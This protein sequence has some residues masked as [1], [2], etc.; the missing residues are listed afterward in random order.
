MGKVNYRINQ[1]ELIKLREWKKRIDEARKGKYEHPFQY[2]KPFVKVDDVNSISRR[3][4][5]YCPIQK[6]LVHLL[7]DGEANAYKF[8]IYQPDV[9]G[10]RE[11][12]PLHL[13]KTLEIAE[14]LQVI[15]PRNWKTKELYIMT[16]DLL[17]DRVDLETGEVYQQAANF[18]YWD[19][20]YEYVNDQLVV[21]KSWRTWQKALI[22]K[23]YWDEKG[24]EFVQRTERDSSKIAVQNI[25]WFQ[26]RHDLNV[27]HAELKRFKEYFIQSYLNNPRLW[28]EEHLNN[29]CKCL[30]T[31]FRDAQAIFQFAAF[32]H[33]FNLNIEYPIRL[34]EP[35]AVNM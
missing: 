31:S 18:K 23:T 10:I 6:R 2:Y 17:V 9:V 16:T 24:V 8:L 14:S 33:E 7:S 15:H 5:Y 22:E 26:M 30:G 13:P 21:R 4:L 12:F 25:T 1:K 35:L 29:V 32:H 19:V 3:H 20:I 27:E 34:S 11:Q 28:L